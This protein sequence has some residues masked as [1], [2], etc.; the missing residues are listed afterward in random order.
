MAVGGVLSFILQVLYSP[1]IQLRFV[2]L[3]VIAATFGAFL[4]W[5]D[6]LRPPPA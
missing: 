5:A 4:L 6:F 2:A 1:A 3:S